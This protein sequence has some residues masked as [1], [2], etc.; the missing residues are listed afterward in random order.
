MSSLKERVTIYP[1]HTTPGWEVGY[2]LSCALP[3]EINVKT[4]RSC[5]KSLSDI[6]VHANMLFIHDVQTHGNI[7]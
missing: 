5:V 6:A 4:A 1:D 7:V 3:Y 2:S